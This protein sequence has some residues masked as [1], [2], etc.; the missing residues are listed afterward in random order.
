MP[1][2]WRRELA[3]A[4]SSTKYTG[5]PFTL[6]KI[7]QIRWPRTLV[8]INPSANT[9][10]L[11]RGRI[12]AFALSASA[13]TGKRVDAKR[14]PCYLQAM[15]VPASITSS[16][17]DAPSAAQQH[18]FA[19]PKLHLR[20]SG[21]RIKYRTANGIAANI[22]C[23]YPNQNPKLFHSII[24][25]KTRPRTSPSDSSPVRRKHL[26]HK[27]MRESSQSQAELVRLGLRAS[28]EASEPR[29]RECAEITCQSNSARRMEVNV[30]LRR[31]APESHASP[32]SRT[33]PNVRYARKATQAPRLRTTT[34]PIE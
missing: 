9:E 23:S 12:L 29:R 26:F 32:S 27:E 34:Q 25:A 24:P 5:Y 28:E 33:T 8:E 15:D 14:V 19:V 4:Y 31:A 10:R 30:A 7:R 2:S 6:L 22:S 3:T 1:H 17:V 20:I 13:A 11:K 16:A 21:G 18:I